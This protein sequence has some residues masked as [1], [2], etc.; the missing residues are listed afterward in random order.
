MITLSALLE[1]LGQLNEW[2]LRLSNSYMLR[3]HMNMKFPKFV[4][5]MLSR[6]CDAHCIFCP[7]SRSSSGQK[8]MSFKVAK[9]V[10]DEL[11]ERDFS[12]TINLGE[13]GDALLNPQFKRILEYISHHLPNVELILFTNAKY[14]N[15]E[16]ST[17]LLN[18]HLSRLVLNI[19][20]A[21]KKT[22][23]FAKP[24][25][26]FEKIKKNLK[27]FIRLRAALKTSCSIFINII[28][29]K[30][31]M[32]VIEN[33]KTNLPYDVDQIFKYWRK[34][35]SKYDEI[36][37]RAYF[38]NWTHRMKSKREKSCPMI[39]Q[40]FRKCYISTEGNVYA[41]CLDYK[42]E[43]L[44]GN[45]LEKSID[46][47]WNSDKRKKIIQNI[48]HRNFELVG[49]PCLHCSE[50]NDFVYSYFILLKYSLQRRLAGALRQERNI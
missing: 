37:E 10:V 20:G 44:Y 42:T 43:L 11:T 28:S 22:Y 36:V 19:D 29:P 26:N 14:L 34:Y 24:N 12:G 27:S 4:G 35:L 3:K 46:E 17:L 16:T 39:Q 23:E 8:F 38:Y 5:L 45:I 33:K 32:E 47:I 6:V 2:C 40:L 48:V 30:L 9:K 18:N 25:C 50:R 21:T 49:E 15:E 1:N 7:I 41:C 13:N 31:Y